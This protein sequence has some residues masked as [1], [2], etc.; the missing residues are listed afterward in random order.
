MFA[1]KRA[2]KVR[3]HAF[4]V[5]ELAV[6]AFHDH[7]V[8]LDY[9]LESVETG[10]AR[11]ERA[12]REFRPIDVAVLFIIGLKRCALELLGVVHVRRNVYIGERIVGVRVQRGDI[13]GETEQVILGVQRESRYMFRAQNIRDGEHERV[14]AAS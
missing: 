7:A 3:N 6:N 12:T 13:R 11:S 4:A 8:V 1:A 9:V 10:V 5:H 2:L 14:F